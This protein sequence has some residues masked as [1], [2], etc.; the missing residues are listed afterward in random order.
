MLMYKKIFEEKILSVTKKVWF[1]I[2]IFFVLI[3][4]GVFFF[5]HQNSNPLKTCNK[6]E[7]VQK[8]ICFRKVIDEALSKNDFSKAFDILLLLSQED[9]NFADSCHSN[10]HSIGKTAYKYYSQERSFAYNPKMSYC[11]FGFFHGFIEALFAE[12][13]KLDQITEFCFALEKMSKIRGI[14][15]SCFHGLGHGSVDGTIPEHWG[16]PKKIIIPGIEVCSQLPKQPEIQYTCIAG[17]YNSLE[18]LSWDK[19][20]R[21][22]TLVE[23]PFTFCNSEPRERAEACY[24]NML[25]VILRNTNQNTGEAALY[26][27]DRMK[28]KS[29]PS[30]NSEDL[31][32][33]YLVSLYAE[34]IRINLPNKEKITLGINECRSLSTEKLRNACIEGLSFGV[35]KYY[36]PKTALDEWY[37][38]CSNSYLTEQEKDTCYSYV[39]GRLSIWYN[40]AESLRI[41][42]SA[43]E[44]YRTVCNGKNVRANLPVVE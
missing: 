30:I 24:I 1:I 21:L 27:L 3:C 4:A 39:L 19:Q 9:K 11:A 35:I 16:D 44:K 18:I 36:P 28:F 32:N 20:Y 41:C 23:D 25:P 22:E 42:A 12:T 29:D 14:Q 37:L 38:L 13:G 33:S 8:Q 10:S 26:G 17:A 5:V 40:D 2:F 31:E 6:L 43:P 15:Y 34:F 7:G